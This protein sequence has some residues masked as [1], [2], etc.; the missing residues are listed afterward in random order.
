M[1][2]GIIARKLAK[3]LANPFKRL[4]RSELKR[5]I[6]AAKLDLVEAQKARDFG[7]C[8]E[9]QGIIELQEVA[10]AEAARDAAC[11][12]SREELDGEIARL[13]TEI[14]AAMSNK[15]YSK[16]DELQREMDKMVQW[17]KG[18]PTLAEV[19]TMI[20]EV[21][22]KLEQALAGKDFTLCAELNLDLEDLVATKAELEEAAA[23]EGDAAA[24]EPAPPREFASRTEL[25]AKIKE[26]QGKLDDVSPCSTSRYLYRCSF[27]NTLQMRLKL[28]AV[29]PRRCFASVTKCV[30]TTKRRWTVSWR[31]A[32]TT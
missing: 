14:Q 12:M 24:T 18:M 16:C 23:A 10:W 15:E 22:S 8:A 32:Q 13:D 5:V 3:K 20:E 6:R 1:V 29:P 30:A 26:V 17:R 11:P 31:C 27:E 25:E 9:L 21:N 7:K 19:A 2:R 28:P 4:E